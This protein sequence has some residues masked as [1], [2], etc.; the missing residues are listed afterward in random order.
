MK[1][2]TGQPFLKI[3]LLY[4]L[5]WLDA[6]LGVLQTR[7]LHQ[8][9]LLL[10]N[11]GL[12]I[13]EIKNWTLSLKFFW[14]SVA[15]FLKIKFALN[16]ESFLPDKYASIMNSSTNKLALDLQMNVSASWS[17]NTTFIWWN[18]CSASLTIE[19]ISKAGC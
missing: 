9:L 7:P 8:I 3:L 14:L 11:N 5:V 2:G 1:S 15:D 18:I 4:H 16:R 10:R 6:T 19:T 13:L 17:W 12:A